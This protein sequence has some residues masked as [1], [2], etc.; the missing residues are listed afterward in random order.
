MK[1][2]VT[3]IKKI[4][5]E[6]SRMRGMAKVLIDDCFLVEDIRIIEGDNG[7]ARKIVSVEE[8]IQDH[9]QVSPPVGITDENGIVFIEVLNAVLDRRTGIV[10][11]LLLCVFHQRIVI[12]GVRHFGF[13]AEDIGT[14]IFLDH[15]RH[16]LRV[17]QRLAADF[18]RA[19]VL[20]VRHGEINDQ[21]LA[22][23]GS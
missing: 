2:E 7:F 1:I 19:I 13:D 8:C 15:I 16:V 3:S 14:G 20:I 11:F 21:R 5:K 22:C 4:E 9:R 10:V 6:G 17:A 23:I 12:G 18:D